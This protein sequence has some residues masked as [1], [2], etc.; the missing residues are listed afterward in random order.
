MK[1]NADSKAKDTMARAKT[2]NDFIVDILFD[3]M[4]DDFLSSY[5]S[6]M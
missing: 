3:D 1:A 4:G 5:V 6:L 2:E